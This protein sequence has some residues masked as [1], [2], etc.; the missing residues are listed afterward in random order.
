MNIALP[1]TL[2]KKSNHLSTFDLIHSIDTYLNL[3][4]FTP[5]G[6]YICDSSFGFTFLNF[7]FEIFNELEGVVNYTPQSDYE[8]NESVMSYNKK[9]SGSSRNIDTFAYDL[10]VAIDRYEQRLNNIEVDI[11]YVKADRV[12]KVYVSANIA[13]T[14]EPYSFETK[15][16]VWNKKL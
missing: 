16:N 1:L 5:K 6:S 9:I 14:E 3:I 13:A 7:Q 15:I 8:T 2:N 12:V 4:I 11:A 10:K